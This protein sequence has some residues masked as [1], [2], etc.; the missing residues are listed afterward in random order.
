MNNSSDDFEPDDF[1]EDETGIETSQDDF[2]ADDFTPEHAPE[3]QKN[4][5][6]PAMY[7]VPAG[8]ENDSYLT[9]LGKHYNKASDEIH[10][11]KKGIYSGMTLGASDYLPDPLDETLE[12]NEN[13]KAGGEAFGSLV[14][15]SGLIK[16]VGKGAAKLAAKSPFLKK[17][18]ESL[19]NITGLGIGGGLYEGAKKGIKEGELPSTND[20]LEHGFEWAALDAALRV[21]GAVGG[22]AV[23]LFKAQQKTGKPQWKLVNEVNTRLKQAGVDVSTDQKAG[24]KAMSILE[25]I[26]EG[27]PQE[28]L[29]KR[30]VTKEQFKELDNSIEGLS[31]PILPEAA[32]ESFSVSNIIEGVEDEAVNSRIDSLG[33]RAVNDT[34]LGNDIQKGVNEA[35]EEAKRSYKPLYDEVEQQAKFIYFNPEETPEI[36]GDLIKVMEKLRTQP[37]KYATVVEALEDILHDVGFKIQRYKEGASKG[38]IETILRE[39]NVPVSKMMELGRRLNEI[40]EYDILDRTVKDRL[41]PV[42]KAV[43][44]DIRSALGEVSDDL[45]ESFNLAEEAHGLTEQKFNRKSI[46]KIRKAQTLESIPRQV[47]T[48]STLNDLRTILTTKQMNEIERNVLERM[49]NMS[50]PRAE[51]FLRKI[52]AGLSPE[53]RSIAEDISRAKVPLKSQPHQTRRGRLAE[54]IDNDISNAMHT[55]KRPEKALELWQ[56]PRGQKLVKE[57]LESHPQSKEIIDYLQK[58]TLQDMAQSIVTKEGAIDFTKLSELMNNKA[59][60]N[61]LRELGGQEAVQFFESLEEKAKGLNRNAQEIATEELGTQKG[62]KVNKQDLKEAEAAKRQRGE[63]ILKR[64]ADKDYPLA[65][66][67]N[68]AIERLGFTGKVSLNL[69]TLIK[70]GFLKGAMIPVGAKILQRAAT[71]NR[72]RKAF[73]EAAKVHTDPLAFIAAIEHLGNIIDS[74]EEGDNRPNKKPK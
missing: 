13:F 9:R 46:R 16:V 43:K 6:V 12:G 31:Q 11:F 26:V 66:K 28:T 17:S 49:K 8:Q 37:A 41:K 22:F 71:D 58:Q 56:N 60:K 61:N 2:E 35:R 10:A 55:G 73:T 62:F 51:E 7:E 25:D 45:L 54:T 30:K 42:V 32:E 19:A 68:R 20:V 38:A 29:A 21:G 59:I 67:I 39:K 47:E 18:V 3:Q 5:G 50:K 27:K 24:A 23:N 69:F 36:A 44:R 65:A 33:R 57:A 48:A 70:F 40:V 52:S 1:T 64:M 74:E 4:V 15:L 34:E 14:P 72:V 63:K 53:A